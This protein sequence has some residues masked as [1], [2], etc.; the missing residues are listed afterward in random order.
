MSDLFA[1]RADQI[2]GEAAPL[3]TRMRPRDLDEVV[4]QPALMGPPRNGKE[5]PVDGHSS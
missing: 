5:K 3:A 1:A 2:K 4:G